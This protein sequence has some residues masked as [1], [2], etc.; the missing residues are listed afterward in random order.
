MSFSHLYLKLL[1]LLLLI[2]YSW[3]LRL[4]RGVALLYKLT[5]DCLFVR[6]SI[7]WREQWFTNG[8]VKPK[9]GEKGEYCPSKF[10]FFSGVLKSLYLKPLIPYNQKALQIMIRK[11]MFKMLAY[12]SYAAYGNNSF[13]IKMQWQ[14]K[15]V[16]L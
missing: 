12:F 7:Q 4:W 11:V 5:S 6:Y 10:Q 9:G 15:C 1:N 3:L 8:V 16:I 13:V 2:R 14:S